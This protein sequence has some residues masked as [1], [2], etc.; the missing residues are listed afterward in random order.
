LLNLTME[1]EGMKSL[2]V[3]L[4]TFVNWTNRR[5]CVDDLSRAG[6][7]YLG[8]DDLTK[9]A[10]CSGEVRKWT[11]RDEPMLEHLRLF[12]LCPFVK[13]PPEY[14]MWGEE[15]CVH[16]FH[17]TDKSSFVKE[18]PSVTLFFQGDQTMIYFALFIL[19][20]LHFLT[21][22]LLSLSWNK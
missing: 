12:P 5:V 18:A 4:S 8:K 11:S 7:Y 10:Y 13:D 16:R 6:F 14:A 2:G 21:L 20:F 22:L 17:E 1:L 19:F 3:R 15:E 9:C